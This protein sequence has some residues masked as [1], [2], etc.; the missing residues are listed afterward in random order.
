[1][2]G[3]GDG[4]RFSAVTVFGSVL[5]QTFHSMGTILGTQ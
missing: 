3:F 5:V 2:N 1:M 4:Q